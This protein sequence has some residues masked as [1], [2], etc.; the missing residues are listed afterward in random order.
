MISLNEN[1]GFFCTTYNE[2]KI[3]CDA[4]EMYKDQ[5]KDI[6]NAKKSINV[7][8]YIFRTDKVGRYFLD[9][10]T[11]KAKEGVEVILVFDDS[12]NPK[13]TYRFL[14]KFINAGG[15]VQLYRK[16]HY[17]HLKKSFVSLRHH[18]RYSD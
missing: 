11:E 9:V 5:I 4:H 10:L 17:F 13:M 7:L 18:H 1:N 14:K 15:K 16:S 2:T 6:K 8:Y 3:Y 12:A